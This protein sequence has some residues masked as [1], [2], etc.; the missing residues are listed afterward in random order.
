MGVF[1]PKFCIFGQNF[2][3]VQNSERGGGNCPLPLPRR[4]WWN[5]SPCLLASPSLTVNLRHSVTCSRR[6]SQW[7]L[8]RATGARSMRNLWEQFERL[9]VSRL[10]WIVES[11]YHRHH[12]QPSTQVRWSISHLRLRIYQWHV[13]FEISLESKKKMWSCLW[14]SFWLAWFCSW[15]P[16]SW[17]HSW[18]R[19]FGSAVSVLSFKNFAV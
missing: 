11:R 13:L 12:R 14:S 5:Q 3:T 6:R 4:Q 7:L 16:S 8:R 15:S 10:R 19:S 9:E 17:S 2:L 18:S 1:S